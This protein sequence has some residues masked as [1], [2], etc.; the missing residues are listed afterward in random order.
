MDEHIHILK[1][2]Y[3]LLNPLRDPHLSNEE[4]TRLLKQASEMTKS[5]KAP[6][7]R[8]LELERLIHKIRRLMFG[9]TD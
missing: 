8:T 4:R 5:L 2:A 6:V 7:E 1:E 9:Y 3:E